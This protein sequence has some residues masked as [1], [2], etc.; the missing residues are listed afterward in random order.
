MDDFSSS[1][2]N[3]RVVAAAM[4]AGHKQ[5]AAF[6]TNN[7][8]PDLAPKF[9]IFRPINDNIPHKMTTFLAIVQ[10]AWTYSTNILAVVQTTK[11]T[12][13]TRIQYSERLESL[14]VMG[15]Q[16]RATLKPL[17]PSNH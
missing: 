1:S 8:V 12:A 5:V 4:H 10:Q 3:T 9:P 13:I 7:D 11:T 6:S 17:K 16:L 15:E 2:L 14:I